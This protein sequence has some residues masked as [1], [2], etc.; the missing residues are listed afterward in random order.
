[1][2]RPELWDRR[3]IRALLGLVVGRSASP[4]P[5]VTFDQ[6]QNVEFWGSGQRPEESN[7]INGGVD[8]NTA[9]PRNS[10]CSNGREKQIEANFH[11]LPSYS[12]S[13]PAIDNTFAFSDRGTL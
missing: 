13:R 5:K 3:H 8:G 2:I 9:T 12:R 6:R 7:S 11:G 1:M 10:L 4:A